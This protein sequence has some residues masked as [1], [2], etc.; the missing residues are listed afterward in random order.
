MTWATV[1]WS[2][3]RAAR[4]CGPG[5]LRLPLVGTPPP[6]L[7]RGI[8]VHTPRHVPMLPETAGLPGI[9]RPPD[10]RR[11][12]RD[13]P[14]A[15][16]FR[17]QG[18][19]GDVRDHAL[20]V[21]ITPVSS[22]LYGRLRRRPRPRPRGRSTCNFFGWRKDMAMAS[23]LLM[24]DVQRNML[25]APTP[26]PE[27]ETVSATIRQ[28][29]ERARESEAVIVHIR[30][31]GGEGDPDAPGTPGWEL[32]HEVRDGEH[33]IDKNENDAF[34]GTK[35]DALIPEESDV[36]MVG[37]QS[38]FCIRATALAALRRDHRVTLVRGAHATYHGEVPAA[39]TS[40]Q[41]DLVL[42]AAGVEVTDPE[43]VTFG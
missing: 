2:Q 42:G 41:I 24:V 7:D 36:V 22:P 32:V 31:N 8:P 43:K 9:Q 13:L 33:V 21:T 11:E 19:P 39:E 23:V 28:I 35:L 20:R 37:M 17:R 16:P 40:R 6:R 15:L 5:A 12:C 14:A 26:V 38:E 34:A 29:L 1:E 18:W 10:S 30:N 25:E 4:G 3:R 27:A